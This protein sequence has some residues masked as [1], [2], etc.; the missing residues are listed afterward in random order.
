MV[1][2]HGVQALVV[3]SRA[4]A[5]AAL[6]H[7][8]Q[9]VAKFIEH[10]PA[11]DERTPLPHQLEPGT[12]PVLG[13]D[14]SMVRIPGG[15]FTMVIEHKRRE[16]GCYHFGTDRG[17]LWGYYYEDLIT[18]KIPTVLRAFAVR[19]TAVTNAEYLAFVLQS[20]Y[21]P[22]DG[23]NFLKQIPRNGQGA[24]PLAL[25]PALA[26]LPVTF[27]SMNDARAFAKWKQQ[28]LPSEAEWQWVAEG[29][30]HSY[31]WPWGNDDALAHHSD[32]VNTTGKITSAG[33][34]IHGGTGLGVLGLT[35]NTWEL[36]ESEYTD[37]HTRF[38]LLRGGVYLPPGQSEWLSVRGP[39]PNQFHAKYILL[40]EGLDR[41]EAIS[42]RT[43][44]DLP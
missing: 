5:T 9:A 12:S 21:R 36:T 1:P 7:F 11:Y 15:A 43:V 30:G 33:S 16:S 40:G 41:S 26:D 24:L 29:A 25:S 32:V 17:A 44:A 20:G 19:K 13:A 28:R 35:G 10:D 34:H 22:A 6:A 39:R 37:G 8:N 14:S 3:D 38:L 27:V 4:H 2:A 23:Q 18:H 42:F 31:R